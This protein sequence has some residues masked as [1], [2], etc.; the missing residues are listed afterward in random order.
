MTEIDAPFRGVDGYFKN[1]VDKL[2]P[3]RDLL[4]WKTTES[5]GYDVVWS[6]E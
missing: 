5:V 3:I 4:L 6:Q 1:Y 2:I